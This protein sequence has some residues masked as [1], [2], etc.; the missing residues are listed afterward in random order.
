MLLVALV[1]SVVTG[2]G[3][4]LAPAVR[5]SHF[6]V[7]DAIKRGAGTVPRHRA[8]FRSSLVVAQVAAAV[9][10]PVFAGLIGRTFLTLSPSHRGF[11]P[12]FRSVFGV[13]LPP[14]NQ[15]DR[16]RALGQL[17][18]RLGTLPDVQGAALGS[19][20][21]FGGDDGFRR[22]A[23]V[24]GPGDELRADLRTVTDGYFEILQTPLVAGRAFSDEGPSP[25]GAAIVNETVAR[26]LGGAVLGRRLTIA[27]PQ[28]P[29]PVYEIVGIVRDARSSGTSTTVWDEVYIPLE[30]SNP[31]IMIAIVVSTVD[32][33]TLDPV[34]RRELRAV[35]PDRVDDPVNA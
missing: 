30:Q 12:R 32:A 33:V 34:I 5:L 28:A 31:S 11:E 20:V 21:P 13:I 7:I 8:R 15:G 27:S 22:I 4:G 16:V 9:A 6:S 17:A 19:N 25:V 35:W 10:L 26:K 29:L 24:D 3:C 14:A 23:V 18:D 2:I 1:L